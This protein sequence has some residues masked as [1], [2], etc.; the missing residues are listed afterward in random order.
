MNRQLK[1]EISLISRENLTDGVRDSKIK[2]FEDMGGTEKTI[3]I[4][5]ALLEK[6]KGDA[7]THVIMLYGGMFDFGN[8]IPNSEDDHDPLP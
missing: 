3:K 5:E 7:V 2:K 8:E 1:L 4:L 6:V